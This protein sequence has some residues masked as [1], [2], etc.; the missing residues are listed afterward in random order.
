LANS[1]IF[2]QNVQILSGDSKRI[3]WQYWISWWSPHK[4]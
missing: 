4:L 3:V 1:R 2:Q